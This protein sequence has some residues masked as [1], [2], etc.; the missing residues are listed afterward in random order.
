[1]NKE[2][3][4][5]FFAL[6]LRALIAQSV[7]LYSV[8]FRPEPRCFVHHFV[9][10]SVNR[11]IE[12]KNLTALF[13]DKMIVWFNI[14]FESVKRA[15]EIDFSHKTLFYEDVQVPVYRS[16]AQAGNFLFQPLIDPRGC[17][18]NI[19]SANDFENS[20]PLPASFVFFFSDVFF[21]CLFLTILRIIINLIAPLLKSIINLNFIVLL[22][23]ILR[24]I[25]IPTY[26]PMSESN[27]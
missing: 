6:F 27:F 25:F 2:T 3:F 15:P 20:F 9:Q 23:N 8:P 14:R 26:R 16:H 1:M 24:I 18:V 19:R 7:E 22:C 11:K 12:I 10:R 13:A 17:R 4:L 5:P 21:Q